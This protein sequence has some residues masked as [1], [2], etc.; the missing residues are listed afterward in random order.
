MNIKVPTYPAKRGDA[1]VMVEVKA[2][3][4]GVPGLVVH[5]VINRDNTPGE[6]WVI[7]HE[8]S[9]YAV[10]GTVSDYVLPTRRE[11]IATALGFANKFDWTLGRKEL[12]SSQEEK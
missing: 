12:L 9:G 5:R 6:T 8:S 1:P 11:A 4:T 10:Q 2:Y 7:T 3:K